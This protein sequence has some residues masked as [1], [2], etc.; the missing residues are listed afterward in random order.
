MT[1]TEAKNAPNNVLITN[2]VDNYSLIIIKQGQRCKTENKKLNIVA[3]ELMS[4][5]LLTQEDIDY[6]N[7]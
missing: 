1:K 6:L 5:G 7:S 4:R 2:L 3:N